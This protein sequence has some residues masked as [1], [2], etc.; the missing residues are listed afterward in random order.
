MCSKNSHIFYMSIPLHLIVHLDNVEFSLSVYT[1]SAQDHNIIKQC[2]TEGQI[3]TQPTSGV[4]GL[5]Y[6]Y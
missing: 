4:S 6:T 3:H 5:R 1:I 2:K